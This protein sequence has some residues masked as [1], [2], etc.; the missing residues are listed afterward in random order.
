MSDAAQKFTGFSQKTLIFLDGLGANN[1]KAWFEEHKPDYQKYV[2]E[3]LQD[4]STDLSG[5]MATID[6]LFIGGKRAVS[7][8]QRDTRFSHDKSPYKTSMWITFK[9]P[10]ED[11]ADAPAYFF[12]I[13]PGSYRY[14]MGFYS[15]S[16]DTMF[17]FRE[18][19]DKEPAEFRKAVAF[20]KKQ[21]CF[22]VEGENYKRAAR[23]ANPDLIDWY[24]RKNMYLVCNKNI[25][26]RLFSNVLVSDLL[27]GFDMI[28]PFYR[29]L[30]RLKSA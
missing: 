18:A 7:R 1:N 4:L 30:L 23:A 14:G 8:I 26:N 20:L 9:R 25:D 16:P 13:S 17:K 24:Q 15:A 19:L 29:Y 11:W 12:E 22:Q 6:P 10:Q 2:L 5:H 28:A 21:T 3:P 27:S